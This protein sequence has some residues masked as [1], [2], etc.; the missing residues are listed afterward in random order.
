MSEI[1]IDKIWNIFYERIVDCLKQIASAEFQEKGWVRNEIH[2]YC[3]FVETMC[4]LYDDSNFE[5]FI[6]ERAKEFGLS[7]HQISK[8]DKIRNALNDYDAKHGCYGDPAI[9]VKDPEWLAI[10]EMAKDALTSLGIVK[11]LDPSKDIF[12]ITLLYT[13]DDINDKVTQERFWVNERRQNDNPF[14]D[15]LN[16]FFQV[17][18]AKMV[19]DNYKDYEI[20]DAQSV[21]LKNLYDALYKYKEAHEKEENLQNILD[22]PEWQKVQALAGEIVKAFDFKR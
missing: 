18:K 15:L 10:R 5:Q 8:L 17:A 20:T 12:K 7:D 11:Y 9:I 13:I 22:D 6:D 16:S 2:D 14:Q 3:T 21:L 19:I 1:M 4:G